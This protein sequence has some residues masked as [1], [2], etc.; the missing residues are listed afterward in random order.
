MGIE[1]VGIVGCG[2]MGGGIAE[3]AIR[4]GYA[5]TVREVS[6]ELV[7]KGRSR[8]ERSMQTAVD[9][10]KLAAAERDAA[11]ARLRFTTGIEDL[12]DCELVVEAASENSQLKKEL[13][14]AL[15]RACKPATILA[16]NTSSIPII[17]LAAVTRRPERVV[18]LHFFNPVPVMKLVEVIRTIRSSDEA[19]GAA[20]AFGESLGKRAILAKD[21][22]G[23]VVNV[24]LVPYLLDAVRLLEQGAATKEDIDEGMRLGCGHPMGPLQ[25]LDFIGIDT[26]YS[27]A[28]I[29]FDELKDLHYAPPPLLK[30]MTIAGLHGRKS[31]HGFYEYDAK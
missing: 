28:E 15:D 14:A 4:S 19:V 22:A 9:K 2:L 25:L 31:G 26:A 20:R 3:A 11:V 29:L 16:S 30:Q 21:R 24:L 12:A 10:G 7:A 8:I 13:F 27:I 23:F 1:K 17:E 5:T 18:G 6:P